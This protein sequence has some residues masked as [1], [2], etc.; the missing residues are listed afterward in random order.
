M[1][2]INYNNI[3]FAFSISRLEFGGRVREVKKF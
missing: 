3:A 2:K 1:L